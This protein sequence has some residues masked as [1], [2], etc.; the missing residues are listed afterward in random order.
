MTMY[1]TLSLLIIA[2]TIFCFRVVKYN[3][4]LPQPPGVCTEMAQIASTSVIVRT[5]R[6]VAEHVIVAVIQLPSDTTGEVQRV[7]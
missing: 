6:N 4:P 1:V 5:K 7:R 2:I 3:Y